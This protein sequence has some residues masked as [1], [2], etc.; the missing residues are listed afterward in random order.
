MRA[1]RSCLNVFQGFD[2]DIR[3]TVTTIH[4]N[5]KNVGH[6]SSINLYKEYKRTK[7]GIFMH[8]FGFSNDS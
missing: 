8:R 1:D 6:A 3:E 4:T 2:R 5:D 7:V